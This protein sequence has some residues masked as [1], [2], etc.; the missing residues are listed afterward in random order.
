MGWDEGKGGWERRKEEG[1]EVRGKEI[2]NTP[3]SI[4]AYIADCWNAMSW[5]QLWIDA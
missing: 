5:G 1:G 2:I 4:A 3:T